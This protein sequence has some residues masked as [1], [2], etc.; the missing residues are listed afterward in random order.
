M[1]TLKEIVRNNELLLEIVN[2]ESCIEDLFEQI[3]IHMHFGDYELA[4]ERSIDIQKSFK[5][6]ESIEQKFRRQKLVSEL[7][8]NGFNVKVVKRLV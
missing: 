8:K 2:E 3:K 6:L 1:V 5:R 7:T 4:M